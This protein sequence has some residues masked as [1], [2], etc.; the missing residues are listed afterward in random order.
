MVRKDVRIHPT[1][2]E[3]LEAMAEDYGLTFS[4][5]LRLAVDRGVVVLARDGVQKLEQA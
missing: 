5:L 1:R 4:D 2:L 3:Q